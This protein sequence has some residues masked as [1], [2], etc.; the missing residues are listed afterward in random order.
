[1]VVVLP[2]P[3]GPRNPVILP[4]VTV[5]DRSST[6]A[7]RRKRLVNPMTSIMPVTMR[8]EG[9]LAHRSWDRYMTPDSV[10]RVG[11]VRE[12]PRLPLLSRIPGWAW[13]S[14]DIVVALLL[15][16]GFLG[17]I[18]S[19]NPAPPGLLDF[20][21]ALATSLP[22]AVRRLSPRAVFVVVLIGGLWMR[23]FLIP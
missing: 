15:A 11:N 17:L 18:H 13:V 7:C 1:M 2:A 10:A 4:G 8:P 16:A 23:E 6:A 14:L 5:K 21:G 22:L 20:T 19:R 12:Q 9:P 3:F